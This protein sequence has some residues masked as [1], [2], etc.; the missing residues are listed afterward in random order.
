[1]NEQ[2]AK[3]KC[4][5]C[6][7][8]IEF[9][10]NDAGRAITCPSCGMDTVLFIPQSGPLPDLPLK[11]KRSSSS[12]KISTL[13]GSLILIVVVFAVLVVWARLTDGPHDEDGPGVPAMIVGG[14]LGLCAAAVGFFLYFIPAIV[15]SKKKKRNRHAILVLNICVGWTFIGWVIALVWACTIDPEPA[16]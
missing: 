15:A 5:H 11:T 13:W 1:M 12:K 6:N 7:Q 9:D 4:Q 3:C 10:S 16:K 8:S 2:L 14:L